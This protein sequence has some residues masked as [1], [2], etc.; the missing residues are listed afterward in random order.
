[1]SAYLHELNH[2]CTRRS[3]SLH[4]LP[5]IKSK[6]PEI[7]AGLDVGSSEGDS[8]THESSDLFI[9]SSMAEEQ[10]AEHTARQFVRVN[11]LKVAEDL[12]HNEVAQALGDF[13][14]Q[15]RANEARKQHGLAREWQRWL[16]FDD[17]AEYANIPQH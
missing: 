14:A 7:I 2:H 6:E 13:E 11:S 17:I 16:V 1:M 4:Y 10:S 9:T 8:A 5:T 3:Q 15:E 12:P